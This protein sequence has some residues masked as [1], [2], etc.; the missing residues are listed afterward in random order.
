MREAAEQCLS[1]GMDDWLIKP[2]GLVEMSQK[3]NL[4]VPLARFERMATVPAPLHLP[5]PHAPA[6]ARVEPGLIDL[7]LLGEISGG[8]QQ[9]QQEILADF[10]RVNEQDAA[11]LRKAVLDD[12]FKR[13]MQL[14]HRIKGANLMLGA[15]RMAA[16]CER[17]ESA[18]SAGQSGA[19]QAAMIVFD[20]ELL[21]LN[22]RWQSI[23]GTMTALQDGQQLIACVS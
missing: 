16:A 12:D 22:L 21:R 5:K 23:G 2:A 7:V 20:A 14:A 11:A 4:W 1:A 3:L 13:V 6:P 9:I 19:V 17:L 15:A 18:G 10:H 8:N